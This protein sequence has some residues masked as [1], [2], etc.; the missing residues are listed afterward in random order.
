MRIITYDMSRI[1]VLR[2]KKKSNIIR[3]RWVERQMVKY[4]TDMSAKFKHRT[5]Q[6]FYDFF[7]YIPFSHFF[8]V[9]KKHI[10]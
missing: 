1:S 2:T 8:N 10:I 6:F 7:R 5:D 9:F 4:D 3:I